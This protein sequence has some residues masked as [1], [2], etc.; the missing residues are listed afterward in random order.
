MGWKFLARKDRRK[1]VMTSFRKKK[2]TSDRLGKCLDAE[3]QIDEGT[4]PVDEEV[5][6][7]NGD[8][9]PRVESL[10]GECRNDEREV[11]QDMESA[12]DDLGK[13]GNEN[14]QPKGMT[15][16]ETIYGWITRASRRKSGPT[17]RSSCR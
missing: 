11:V 2:E 14:K 1:V 12:V 4:Q 15:L 7:E 16:K 13:D 9:E 5:E 17:M 3:R 10:G 8:I 6:Q